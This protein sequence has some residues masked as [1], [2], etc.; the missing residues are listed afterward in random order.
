MEADGMKPIEYGVEVRGQ[1][2]TH[3]DECPKEAVT[4]W[5]DKLA[6]FDMVREYKSLAFSIMPTRLQ[7]R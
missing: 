2:R 3:S 4:S 5:Q 1:D 7:M 6:E